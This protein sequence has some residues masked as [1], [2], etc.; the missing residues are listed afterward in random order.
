MD[1]AHGGHAE[2][3]AG[4]RADKYG[5]EGLRGDQ[6]GD[7]ADACA[8]RDAN[9]D[10][11]LALDRLGDYSGEREALEKAMSLDA[12]LAPVHNQLG[13]LDLQ[14]GQTANAE[15][16][17]KTAISLDPQ[18]A[19]ALNNRGAGSG[20]RLPGRLRRAGRAMVSDTRQPHEQEIRWR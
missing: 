17:F 18:Y 20:P 2:P 3:D 13:F 10:L 15:D 8:D 6:A 16:Q 5:G 19:E 7:A 9:A 1:V 12:S 14:A 11:A 4:D